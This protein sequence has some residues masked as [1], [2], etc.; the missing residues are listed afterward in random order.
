MD[1]TPEQQ[2]TLGIQPTLTFDWLDEFWGLRHIEKSPADLY[3]LDSSR[4]F[5]GPFS[6][7]SGLAGHRYAAQF[8]NE[9]GSGSETQEGRSCASKAATS[10]SL[11]S[12]SKVSIVSA[13]GRRASIA[14]R[15]K[16]SPGFVALRQGTGGQY[17]WQVRKP[18][19]DLPNQEISVWSGFA[20]WER[21][22][23]ADLFFRVDAVTGDLGGVETGLPWRGGDRL[24]AVEQS[25]AVHDVDRWRGV[26]C[27]SI[28]PP[29]PESRAREIQQRP[30]RREFPGRR[31]DS[32]L[33]FTFFWTF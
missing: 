22:N 17:L 4:D 13:R 29:G 11:G 23:R 15:L 8:G 24:L 19:P 30:G 5:A 1:G 21:P 12:P 6:G 10:G 7:P 16:A 9:S 33:R 20:V 18:G 31:Q 28:R 32:I 3:R 2:L 27:T 26:H 25:I 14:T